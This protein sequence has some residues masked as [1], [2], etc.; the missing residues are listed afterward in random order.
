MQKQMQKRRCLCYLML[1][2]IWEHNTVFSLC[3]KE[4][5]LCLIN[6]W[7]SAVLKCLYLKYGCCIECSC[8]VLVTNSLL[9]YVCYVSVHNPALFHRST[10]RKVIDTRYQ[11]LYLV[12]SN[13]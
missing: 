11:G 9:L 5:Y 7:M 10:T 2:V 13:S 3:V 8:F 12:N 4:E 6:I 1:S